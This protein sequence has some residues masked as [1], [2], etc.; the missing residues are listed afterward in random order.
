MG[1]PEGDLIIEAYVPQ[2]QER[3]QRPEA[4][5]MKTGLPKAV[6]VGEDDEGETTEEES[7]DN[8][9]EMDEG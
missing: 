7:S 1:G 8:G 3:S 6:N 4:S 9:G 5:A 2:S